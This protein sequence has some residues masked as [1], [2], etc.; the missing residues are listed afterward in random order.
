M[1]KLISACTTL[2]P[3]YPGYINISR[4]DD[5]AV[6]I[7]VRGDPTVRDGCYVCGHA[8]DIGKPGRCTPGDGHCNNYCNMAPQKGPMV[9]APLPCS[10]TIEGKTAV[11]K[12]SA[13][14]WTKLVGELS[15]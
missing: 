7:I 14:E 12:L 15:A 2:A 8:S 4:A 1:S 6:V 9:D 11:V 5:G 10:Q 13:D 3:S